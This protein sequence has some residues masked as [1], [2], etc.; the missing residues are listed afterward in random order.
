[1]A[2]TESSKRKIK[3]LCSIKDCPLF[4]QARGWCRVHYRRWQKHG[5]PLTVLSRKQD[6]EQRF[7]S[8][9]NKTPGLGK[10]GDCW[11]W[12][13][14]VKGELYGKF[15]VDGRSQY[16]HRYAFFL[17]H[18]HYPEPVGRHT[19]DNPPCCNPSHIIEGTQ[20]DNVRDAVARNRQYHA[21][22]EDVAYS[23]LTNMNVI[24]MRT[25]RERGDSLRSLSQQFSVSQSLVSTVC[26][27]KKWKHV[28]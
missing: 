24:Q 21:L 10:D 20:G 25:Q 3:K 5:N 1:M 19:C 26:S 14:I 16:A 18:G 27:R 12:K 9:V 15:Y 22:G 8:K 28:E 4:S 7:W 23:K 6:A 17:T 13:T 2:N 11:E